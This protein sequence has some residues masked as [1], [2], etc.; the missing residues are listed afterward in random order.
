MDLTTISADEADSDVARVLDS[1][2]GTFHDDW[3]QRA[4]AFVEMVK[5]AQSKIG[6]HCNRGGP[7]IRGA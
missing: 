3:A 5:K 1:A 6:G 4:P 7:G 2:T